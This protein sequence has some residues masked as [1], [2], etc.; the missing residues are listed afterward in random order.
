MNF[1]PKKVIPINQVKVFSTNTTNNYALYLIKTKIMTLD[2]I[3]DV[4]IDIDI[5]PKK[6]I[7]HTTKIVPKKDIEAIIFSFEYKNHL[8][9][10]LAI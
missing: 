1:R 6:F 4:E 5:L 2:G 8:K 7:V 10:L 9:V 3:K